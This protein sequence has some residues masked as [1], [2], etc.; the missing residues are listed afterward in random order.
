MAHYSRCPG[1]ACNCSAGP[2]RYR[3]Y[4]AILIAH[5]LKLAESH[6]DRLWPQARQSTDIDNYLAGRTAAMQAGTRPIS[7]PSAP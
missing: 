3:T 7:K 1:M 2:A 4:P 5:E 6:R